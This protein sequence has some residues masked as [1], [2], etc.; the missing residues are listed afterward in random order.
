MLKRIEDTLNKSCLIGLSYFN[1]QGEQ[2][3][4]N[5][6]AG[7]VISVDSELGIT[8]ELSTSELSTNN[9]SANEK[10]KGANFILPCDLSCWF[11]APKGEFH[12]SQKEV[13]IINP[14]CLVT[15]D[16]YQARAQEKSQPTTKVTDG[17]QQWWQW[18]PRT[19]PPNVG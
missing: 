6:L 14:D 3:K 7:R 2:L 1:V 13:K 17:E 8:I 12:T 9:L 4:Q 18:R 5:I 10:S 16:I 15:W 11:T 19:Q